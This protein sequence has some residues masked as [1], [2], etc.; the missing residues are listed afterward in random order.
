MRTA[1]NKAMAIAALAQVGSDVEGL[2]CKQFC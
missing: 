1:H 2:L